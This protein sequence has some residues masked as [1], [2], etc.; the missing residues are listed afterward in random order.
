MKASFFTRLWSWLWQGDA[1]AK[2]R[3]RIAAKS[4]RRSRLERYAS[5][6][7]E[8]G[9][10][11]LRPVT[12]LR[13][14]PG[15]A[16][17]ATLYARSIR[18]SVEALREDHEPGTE[19]AWMRLLER[20]LRG[21]IPTERVLELAEG[22]APAEHGVDETST[23]GMQAGDLGEVARA[24]LSIV[25]EA[26]LEERKA[27]SRRVLRLSFGFLALL[28]F[29][30]GSASLIS[31]VAAG[32]DLAEGKTWRASSYYSGF[33]PEAGICDGRRTEIFFHTNRENQP[34][35]EIDLGQPTEVERVDIQNR[36]DCCRDRAFPLAVEG[37]LDGEEWQELARRT[38]PFSKW[39][40]RFPPTTVRYV[41][42][43]ALKR[44]YF[45]LESVEVR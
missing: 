9:D 6:A 3:R 8:V 12:P 17:A 37:S 36:R 4:A 5:T 7:A 43:K 44:T 23:W 15:D 26:E 27:L 16:V 29:G 25:R 22:P 2:S 33:S 38:Q 30:I 14:G 28:A 13:S 41:R 18:A 40:A 21:R 19:A 11:A 35:V 20:Q 1:V 42:V 34:W 39:I 45:H 24:L 32:P 10:H 31:R